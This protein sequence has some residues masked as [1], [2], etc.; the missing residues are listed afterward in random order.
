MFLGMWK[1]NIMDSEGM[2]MVNKKGIVALKELQHVEAEAVA[3][4]Y[5]Q[6]IHEVA[7]EQ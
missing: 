2:V 7:H 6:L 4:A 3:Y 5:G 1:R